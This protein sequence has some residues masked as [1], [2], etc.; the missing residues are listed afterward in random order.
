MTFF[1][2]A[3]RHNRS[4]LRAVLAQK[5][6]ST[7]VAALM[8]GGMTAPAHAQSA[9]QTAQTGQPA[10][11]NVEEIVVT[12]SRIVRDGYQAPT[13]VT[14]V[15][16]ADIADAAPRDLSDFVNKMP[17]LSGSLKPTA[18]VT[19]VSAGTTG[20]NALNLRALGLERTLVLLDGQ[21]SVGAAVSN[22]VDVSEFPQELVSRVD[23]VTGG[24]SAA[25][26]SDAVSG[27]VNFILD[28]TYTGIKGEVSGGI[29]TYGDDEHWKVSL[30]GGTPFASGRGHFLF[31]AEATR[32]AGI[33]EGGPPRDWMISGW[34]TIPNP[35]YAAT[36]GQPQY[37]WR[38]QVGYAVYQP[39]GI[40]T[41]GPLK[42]IVFGPGGVARQFDYGDIVGGNWQHGGDWNLTNPVRTGSI[43]P[44]GTRQNLFTR[45]NYDLT[46]DVQVF[47]QLSWA[48]SGA[49][50]EATYPFYPGTL[51]IKSDNAFLPADVAARARALGVTQFTLGLVPTDLYNA[52]SHGLLQIGGAHDRRTNRYVFGGNGSFDAADT[53]WKWNAHYSNETTRISENG[54]NNPISANLL[55]AIDAVRDPV[56]GLIVCRSTLTAPNNGCAPYDPMGIGMRN[57]EAS[58]NYIIGAHGNAHRN[59]KVTMNNIA[60]DVNGEPFSSWAGPVSLAFGVEWRKDRITGSADPL[61]LQL[62][63]F[64][65]NYQP[66]I[67][68]VSTM[69]GFAETVIPLAKDTAWA[70][71]LDLNAAVR[72]TSYS[73]VGFV[74]TWKT[75]LVYEPVNDVRFRATRSRDIRA[76]NFGDLYA[77][78]TI[79][80]GTTILDRAH[81]N[82]PLAGSTFSQGNSSLHEETAD[83]TGLGVVL[84]PSFFPGFNAAVDYW[85]I[86]LTGGIGSLNAQQIYD[87]CY[88]GKQEFCNSISVNSVG[89]IV[90]IARPFNVGS[91]IRRGLDFEASYRVQMDTMA[92]N[93]GGALTLRFLA[94]NY[95][96]AYS[97]NNITPALNSVGELSGNS[98]PA[99]KYNASVSYALDAF[100]ASVTATGF[101]GGKRNNTWVECTSGCPTSTIDNPTIENNHI[102]GGFYLSTALSYDVSQQISV[103]FNVE[104]LMNTDPPIISSLT[105]SYPG[106]TP[107]NRVLWDAIGR[108]FRAGVRF[109]M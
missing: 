31:S 79:G 45:F 49:R 40:I 98:L 88:L 77:G 12:G 75:G 70:N 27:V 20:V 24:A 6:G 58:I 9:A 39:G 51:P 69:E 8:V 78:G 13:P 91:E 43:D 87:Q 94:T 59:Q 19:N 61:A 3:S 14:V 44:Q 92:D 4:L 16:A 11:A 62:A 23:V 46:D 66:T 97:N 60:T 17:A 35:S 105:G 104:N 68:Q 42:G 29:T 47:A 56:T 83:T 71:S 34:Q 85:N 99:W 38:S 67:G 65:N 2:M 48:H 26:G 84:Q 37:L 100:H 64:S 63:Y 21:R 22:I 54:T 82:A 72:F 73:S 25:Y 10:A 41:S 53:T 93:L 106:G 7:A 95:L 5:L 33:L 109:K 1:D 28:K 30:T 50:Y 107:I 55:R 90:V 81:N 15:G 52:G 18:T 32:N 96:K 108:S 103:F 89:V 36:N 57:S 80:A 102:D 86:D 74:T 76:P 101:S